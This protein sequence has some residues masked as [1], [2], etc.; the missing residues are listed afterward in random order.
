MQVKWIIECIVKT[1][2]NKLVML[3]FV[4]IFVMTQHGGIM[5]HKFKSYYCYLDEGTPT[6]QTE[7]PKNFTNLKYPYTTHCRSNEI[8][9]M[10][11][12]AALRIMKMRGEYG[13]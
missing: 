13:H 7:K 4:I 1:K 12:L 9:E 5:A 11:Y 3:Q 8:A 2:G 10:V 6:V